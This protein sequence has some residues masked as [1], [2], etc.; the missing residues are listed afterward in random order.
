VKFWVPTHLFHFQ[1]FNVA[2]SERPV[3]LNNALLSQGER[4]K[5]FRFYKIQRG[6]WGARAAVEEK[7]CVIGQVE[8][9]YPI[10]GSPYGRS[11]LSYNNY[12]IET[13]GD[14]IRNWF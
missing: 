1:R 14:R 6:R 12:S 7:R 2:F 11:A 10:T 13:P 9:I 4:Q 5:T 8:T 3:V